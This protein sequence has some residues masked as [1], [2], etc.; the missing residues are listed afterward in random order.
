MEVK[1]RL[2]LTEDGRVVPDGDPDVRWLFAAKGT[3]ITDGAAAKYGI[4]DGLAP[5]PES[6]VAPGPEPDAEV[7]KEPAKKKRRRSGRGS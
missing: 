3:E 1:E 7:A 4:V 2:Y 5:Q 6:K